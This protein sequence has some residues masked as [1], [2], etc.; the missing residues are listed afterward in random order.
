MTIPVSKNLISLFSHN[1]EVIHE[2]LKDI[3]QADSMLQLPFR[4]NCMNWVIGHILSIR[5]ESLILLKLPGLLTDPENKIYG[6]G[7]EP[8]VESAR[9][10]DLFDLLARLDESLKQIT[11]QLEK[12]TQ[13]ELESEVKIW[14]GPLPLWEA[15]S[16]MQWHEAYHTGQLEFL[17][18]LAGKNDHVF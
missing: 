12:L 18:Q 9:A 1:H 7:S 11:L 3:S 16:L 14:R 4:G 8:L 15:L 17:R 6:Y 10:S 13:V 2:Q 5:D